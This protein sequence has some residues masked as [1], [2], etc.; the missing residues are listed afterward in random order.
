[1][2]KLSIRKRLVFFTFPATVEASCSKAGQVV[3]KVVT[4]PSPRLYAPRV[5][6]LE[7]STRSRSVIILASVR[8]LFFSILMRGTKCMDVPA[9]GSTA[10]R[11]VT[12]ASSCNDNPEFGF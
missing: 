4:T 11:K 6:C 10:E 5:L 1:M 8:P 9:S 12:V 3:A 7:A 2:W